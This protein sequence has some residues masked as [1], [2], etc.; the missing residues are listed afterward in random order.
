M[1][2][3]FATF[4]VLLS[5]A[6]VISAASLAGGIISNSEYTLN[7]AR[8]NLSQSSAAYD[9]MA[10]L[11][12]NSSTAECLAKFEANGSDCLNNYTRYYRHIY[13]ITRIGVLMPGT[14]GY[15]Y[16]ST[17]CSNSTS[18]LLCVGVS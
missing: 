6:V 14:A 5:L 18:G 1:K 17:Y 9:F 2:A 16:S 10:Q 3:Q 11:M 8:S 15:N 4:E 7:R 13:G 12:Q